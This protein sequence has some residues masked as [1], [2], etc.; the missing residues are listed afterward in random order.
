MK[1]IQSKILIAFIIAFFIIGFSTSAK[2]IID[3]A[4]ETTGPTTEP[5]TKEN[6]LAVIYPANLQEARSQSIDFVESFTKSQRDYILYVFKKGEHF[7]PKADNILDKY[8]VPQELQMIPLLESEF[9]ADAVSPVGA[10][11]YWQFMGELA[12]EYG[13]KTGGKYDERKNFS[14]STAAAAKFFK[15]Q[16]DYF[17]NDLLLCVASYNCGPGRVQLA[18]KKSG[19]RDAD[20]WDIKRFLPGETKKFVMNFIA[21]NVVAAN[22]D[23]FL[24]NT[25]NFDEPPFIKVQPIQDSLNIGND[26][27]TVKA[28]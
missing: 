17:N 7:F 9:N 1:T 5:V 25:L 27:L 10:V 2:S 16:L 24:N 8:D 26:S 21:Y 28:L 20:Y 18:I 13:L 22:Y 19:K 23:K 12:R 6:P 14:K 3:S 11:G 15:D 4:G